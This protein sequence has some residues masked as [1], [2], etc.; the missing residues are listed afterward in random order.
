C[1]S[2][3]GTERADRA[4]D[5]VAAGR[6]GDSRADADAESDLV[7]GGKC[8]QYLA[9]G[10]GADLPDGKGGRQRDR[11]RM[12]RRRYMGIIDLEAVDCGAVGEGGIGRADFGDPGEHRRD[13]PTAETHRDIAGDSAPRL[14][15]A[16]NSTADRVENTQLE[17]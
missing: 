8:R 3:G 9:A 13:A 7:S 6:V 2:R 12:E 14:N 15:R 17:M 16:V 1:R 10:C 11:S 4:G 5:V